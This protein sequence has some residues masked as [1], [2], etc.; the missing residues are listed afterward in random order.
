[1]P[2][3]ITFPVPVVTPVQL[4]LV[5][6]EHC[7]Q[8]MMVQVPSAVCGKQTQLLLLGLLQLCF[9][10]VS[11]EDLCIFSSSQLRAFLKAWTSRLVLGH[12]CL[13]CME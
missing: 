11:V 4:G 2:R 7:C 9:W 8:L 1:M 3:I 13:L 6:S 10:A 12:G 5:V